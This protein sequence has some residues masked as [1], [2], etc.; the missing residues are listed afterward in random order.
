MVAFC[1]CRLRTLRPTLCASAHKV[2]NIFVLATA[3]FLRR[4]ISLN[5]WFF[6]GWWRACVCQDS[7]PAIRHDETTMLFGICALAY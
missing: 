7:V 5:R 1:D 6:S 4:I 3:L 2:C